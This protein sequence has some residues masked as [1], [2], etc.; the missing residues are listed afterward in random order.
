MTF[1]EIV[2]LFSAVCLF[3]RICMCYVAYG[4]TGWYKSAITSGS[5]L[6]VCKKLNTN[7]IGLIKNS[8]MF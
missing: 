2:H 3:L 7:L 4:T 6:K 8:I 5:P 1:S